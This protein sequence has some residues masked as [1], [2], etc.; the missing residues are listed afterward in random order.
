MNKRSWGSVLAICLIAGSLLTSPSG[1]QTPEIDA[2]I[3]E[4]EQISQEASVQNEL[5]KAAELDIELH[6]D[7]LEEIKARQAHYKQLADEASATAVAQRAEIK[8]LA[9]AKYRGTVLDPISVAL[10][11]E[12]PQNVIDRVSYLSTIAK[13]TSEIMD[14]L[15]VA[16]AEAADHLG[17]ANRMK[18]EADFFLGNLQR[19]FEELDAE[20][21]E[22]LE[23]QAEIKGRVDSLTEEQR[24]LWIAKNTPIEVDITDFLGVSGEAVAAVEAALSKIGAPYV[25]GATGPN[26]FDCSGLIYWAFQQQGKAIPRTSQAQMAGGTPV[27]PDQL[28]PG[29][30]I[31][32]YPGAT[33]VG[34]YIGEGKIVHASDYG[35]PVQVVSVD[36]APIF[37]ARRY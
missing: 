21:K 10:N 23:R 34:L 3:T 22:L 28:E 13:S 35:I 15:D 4:L 33:H 2:L 5:V 7:S 24:Q 6:R 20:Q 37:G 32:Y 16:T 25:W 11:G 26:D 31:G 19:H 1:A 14:S 27:S 12:N 36:S 8:R 17:E 18:A 29:D 30:I 9:Q